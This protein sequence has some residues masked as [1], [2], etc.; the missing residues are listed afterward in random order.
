MA[1]PCS[2]KLLTWRDIRIFKDQTEQ[3]HGKLTWGASMWSVPI[4]CGIWHHMTF[5]NGSQMVQIKKESKSAGQRDWRWQV[6]FCFCKIHDDAVRK[7]LFTSELYEVTFEMIW[8]CLNS[9]TSSLREVVR[10][11]WITLEIPSMK[12]R[13][14]LEVLYQDV[15]L[16]TTAVKQFVSNLFRNQQDVQAVPSRA[17]V[18]RCSVRQWSLQM[19]LNLWE[20]SLISV[21]NDKTDL[22]WQTENANAAKIMLRRKL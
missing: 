4:L 1:L 12:N 3:C 7:K 9:F 16:V 15:S 17:R 13:L 19:I 14:H 21:K 11:I 6:N 8:S 2:K 5:F 18:S 22:H 20:G 10:I